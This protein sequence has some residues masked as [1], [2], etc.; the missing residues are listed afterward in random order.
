MGALRLYE[1][2]P[3][4]GRLGPAAG[5]PVVR[6]AVRPRQP[7]RQ[8]PEHDRLRAGS[9]RAPCA[10]WPATR[11]TDARRLARRP[12]G[13]DPRTSSATASWPTSTWSRTRRYYGTWDATPLYLIA[14][15]EAWRWLGDETL[16]ED[17]P[18]AAVR[19]LEWIDQYGDLDGDGFQEYQTRSSEGLREHG[20]EGRGRRRR[21]SRRQPGRRSRRRSA[22][23]RAT[24]T[25]RSAH[26]RALRRARRARPRRRAAPTQAADAQAALQRG[27]L[28]GGRGHLR[29]R[30][31][32][33][34]AADQDR[35]PPTPATAS[36]AASS[37]PTRPRRVVERAAR[38]RTCG[39]AGAS[40]RSRR[41]N[42]AYNPFSYQRGSVWPHDNG[43]IA[44]GLQALRL[45]R[46]A[47]QPGRPGHLRRGRALRRAT[48]C[49]RSSP[50]WSASA[51][52][53]PVQYL[54]ANIPQAWAAG[55]VFQLVQ[56]MLGLRADAP[57]GRLWVNPTPARLAPVAG[58]RRP[59]GRPDRAGSPLLARGC[60]TRFSV[61]SQRGD[62]LDV[63]SGTR[64]AVP[65]PIGRGR[66][67]WA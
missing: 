62:R 57:N 45:R 12:A 38:S 27:V 58:A 14:L 8:P 42:P 48:A 31:G 67:G 55:S 11:P 50:A 17:L 20:L 36:G 51:G 19:C 32:P 9:P 26:G 4:P 22:S 56:A 53:F 47:G 52:S 3:R 5:V 7:D 49:P 15:H 59:E 60:V 33:G 65:G 39:A 23:C 29:L 34:Q 28:D 10:R 61:A 66:S 2:R 24:S 64:P 21:L 30:P 13:Q 40:G 25:T 37:T 63:L 44:A 41:D 54:G 43:I 6:D 35:S 46:E 16:L 1:R 18:R